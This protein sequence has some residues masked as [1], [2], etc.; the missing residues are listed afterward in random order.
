MAQRGAYANRNAGHK[1]RWARRYAAASGDREQLSAAY[2]WFRSAA[3][4]LARRRTPKGTGQEVHQAAAARLV[5]EAA[6]HLK[7]LAENIDRGEYDA[8]GR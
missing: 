2:D 3:E 4:L 7:T 6:E 1:D 5:R 8:Q